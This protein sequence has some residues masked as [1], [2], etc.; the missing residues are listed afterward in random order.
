[1]DN[2]SV[3]LNSFGGWHGLWQKEGEADFK[4]RRALSVRMRRVFGL[5]CAVLWPFV[6]VVAHL[7][8]V[9]HLDT[10]VRVRLE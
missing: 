8:R 4:G 9:G 10:A 1:M 6:C 5:Q 7:A 3:A 2:K